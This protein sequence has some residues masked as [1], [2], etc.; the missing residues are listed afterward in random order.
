MEA[1]PTDS[2]VVVGHAFVAGFAFIEGDE[3]Q[4]GFLVVQAQYAFPEF[5][6]AVLGPAADG[7]KNLPELVSA[8]R[9]SGVCSRPGKG[10]KVW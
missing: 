10:L 4:F 6:S 5:G 3:D 9:R 8:C 1:L 7:G 2:I